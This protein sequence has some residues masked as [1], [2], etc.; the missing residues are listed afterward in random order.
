MNSA[1][2]F[3]SQNDNK[4]KI[5]N[6]KLIIRNIE[7]QNEI[8]SFKNKT[9]SIN[10]ELLIDKKSKSVKMTNFLKFSENTSDFFYEI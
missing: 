6:A 5:D 1:T 9:S 4:F 3:I 2:T 8:N 10:F 7:L